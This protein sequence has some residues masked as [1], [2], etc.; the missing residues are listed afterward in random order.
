M[1]QTSSRDSRLAA[2]LAVQERARG[3]SGW[4]FDEV[5][6]AYPDGREP[7]DYIAEA[8]ALAASA[9]S[10]VDLGTGGGERFAEILEGG[11]PG[12]LFATEQWHVN[13]PVARDRLRPLGVDAV[14]ADATRLP[15]AA[16]AFDLVLNRHEG[17]DP[18]EIDRVLRP[19]GTFLTQQVYGSW[20]EL[21]AFFPRMVVHPRHE[22]TY[23]DGFKA[24]GYAVTQRRHRYR[25]V[26]ATLEDLAFDLLV[27]PWEI[28]GLE[29]E[30]D[31]DALLA[32]ER[33]LGTPEG[34]PL[35]EGRYLLT[36]RKPGTS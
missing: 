15:F 29:V 24:A 28:P 18:A 25:A 35:T 36:A 5:R 12:R 3:F 30:A 21:R 31:L 16:G 22:I 32:L 23:R 33:E 4:S 1:S 2:L 9:S 20:Q 19:G 17:V 8:R 13:A 7:W 11:V 34:I 10:I 14:R 27:A 6:V 26:F